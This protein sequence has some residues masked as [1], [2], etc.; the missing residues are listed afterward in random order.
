VLALSVLLVIVGCVVVGLT[1][2]RADDWN[3]PLAH[4]VLWRGARIQ[5]P[6]RER[7]RALG[8]TAAAFGVLSLI[9]AVWFPGR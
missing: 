7:L 9:L 2:G 8:Y 4:F 5:P 6:A 1:I 3:P